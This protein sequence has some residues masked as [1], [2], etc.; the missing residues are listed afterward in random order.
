MKY[1]FEYSLAVVISR[2]VRVLPR[3]VYLWCGRVVGSLFF[4]V[5]RKHRHITI[6]HVKLAFG[7]EKS[8]IAIKRTARDSFRHFGSMLFELVALKCSLVKELD[9]RVCFDGSENFE[10][11][12][13]LG[14]G[15]ILV[16][17]HY[18]NWELHAIAHGARFD[19][20]H[21]VARRQENPYL[22]CWLESIRKISGNQVVYKQQALRRTRTLIK[23]GETVAFVID[24][25]V[26]REE[27]VFVDF[28]GR[29]AATT[30][31]AAWFALKTGAALVPAFSIPLSD[32]RYRLVYEKAVDC[33]GYQGMRFEDAVV[34]VTQE[35]AD[36]QER[37]IRAHPECW[38][39]MH[40]RWKTRPPEEI[41]VSGPTTVL[42]QPEQAEETP[43][44][45]EA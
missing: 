34:A 33:D 5:D 22:N 21:V 37:Y 14:K 30:P 29:K 25:N 43:R 17:A 6:D 23:K 45:Y 7:T 18:G 13:D 39:W 1:F 24:Q 10:K 15:V 31:V 16:T 26:S 3:R 4:F 41:K 20:M 35:L 9:S 11:A 2:L 28:F 40:R 19:P 27:A 12:S 42:L 32:G 38:L 36:V 8:E 44:V